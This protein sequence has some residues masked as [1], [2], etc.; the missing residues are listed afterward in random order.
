[1]QKNKKVDIVE[2]DKYIQKNLYAF[3]GGLAIA[4]AWNANDFIILTGPGGYGKTDAA[5]MFHNYLKMNDKLEDNSENAKPFV[6]SFGQGTTEEDMFS[7][8]DLDLFQK[9]GK[10]S[11]NLEDAFVNHEYVIFEEV[12]DAFPGILLKLKQVLQARVVNMGTKVFP[13]KCKFIIGCTNRSYEDIAVDDSSKALLERFPV[14]AIIKWSTWHKSDYLNAL[15]AS[16]GIEKA[17]STINAV[18]TIASQSSKK[19]Q[20][21]NLSPRTVVK[22]YNLVVENNNDLSLLHY[23]YGFDVD[24][25]DNVKLTLD[26]IDA[27]NNQKEYLQ[28]VK[29][30]MKEI[31]SDIAKQRSAI[32]CVALVK[33]LNEMY[34][35]LTSVKRRDACLVIFDELIIMLSKSIPLCYLKAQTLVHKNVPEGSLASRIKNT[36]IEY[37]NWEE[38]NNGKKNK[39]TS[40]I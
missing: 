32:K 23:M 25:V 7:G 12:F 26:G 27:D 18:A 35:K 6:L 30:K 38:V 34:I 15:K 29:E 2:V 37:F 28:K 21:G 40:V 14:N 36:K 1:M 22:G 8:I 9:T 5:I 3:N 20:E 31:I 19:N 39:T 11:Y 4:A 13:L 16:L 10:L 33:D 17:N 24:S